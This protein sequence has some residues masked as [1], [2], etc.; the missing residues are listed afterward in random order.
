MVSG[1]WL[2]KSNYRL[3]CSTTIQWRLSVITML[4]LPNTLCLPTLRTSE[5]NLEINYSV[6]PQFKFNR[7]IT[8]LCFCKQSEESQWLKA[9]VLLEFGEWLYQHNLSK[10]D[11]QQQV[12][13]AINILLQTES[14]TTGE[15]GI[16]S[17]DFFYCFQFFFFVL[18]L[19][20]KFIVLDDF[21]LMHQQWISQFFP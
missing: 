15:A 11:G 10:D 16:N 5:D 2:R 9:N 17:S 1:S 19:I 18:V 21:C 14:D 8:F 7:I 3:M 6:S 12:H 4:F 20:T 13:L